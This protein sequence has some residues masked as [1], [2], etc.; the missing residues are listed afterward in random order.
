MQNSVLDQNQKHLI[1]LLDI[2]A[3]SFYLAWWTA[4]A[5]QLWHRKSIDF[6][7]FSFKKIDPQKII[8]KLKSHKFVVEHILV[9]NQ[10]ELTI[11]IQWVKI[12]FLYYPFPIIANKT[13]ISSSKIK[14]PDL[15]TL[16]ATKAYTIWR[17]S[18]R[19]DYVDIYFLTQNNFTISQISSK[20]K[21][22]FEWVFSEK[23]FRRQLWYF[24]DIDYSE[25]IDF[26]WDNNIS[27]STIQSKLQKLSIIW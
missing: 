18:K 1:S 7:L 19:K 17:R 8:L 5:L 24:Q 4:I 14:S 3:E 13:I 21:T 9:D 22:I 27:D 26:I 2:F 10:D 11:I 6:D 25:T 23:L 12:T 15:L 16:W 20:A